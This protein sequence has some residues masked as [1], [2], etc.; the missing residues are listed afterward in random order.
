MWGCESG[1]CLPR[2]S[3]V[4]SRHCELGQGTKPKKEHARH[5]RWSKRREY[6]YR[7]AYWSRN[8]RS[9][10]SLGRQGCR[11]RHRKIQVPQKPPL[12]PWSWML[13]Q[14]LIRYSL[15]LLQEHY[16]DSAAVRLWIYF[17]FLWNS[18]L[19]HADVRGVQYS[20]HSS[21]DSLVFNNGLWVR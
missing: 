18:N 10:G 3:Q 2:F 9:R 8:F 15:Y 14:E 6:D 21:A 4:K 5:R 11:L 13:S 16:A 20:F 17:G 7:S 12:R 1:P 19:P